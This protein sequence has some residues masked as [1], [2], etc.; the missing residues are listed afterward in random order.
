[1]FLVVNGLF[2]AVIGMGI[3]TNISKNFFAVSRN[4]LAVLIGNML[5]ILFV[6]SLVILAGCL[7]LAVTVDELFSMPAE[8]WLA[9]PVLSFMMMVN[10]INLTLLRNEGRAYV[11][12]GFEVFNTFLSLAVTVV[13]LV[14]FDFGWYSQVIGLL[15]ANAV[16]FLVAIWYIWRRHYLKLTLRRDVIKSILQLS[17]PLIPHV[18]GGVVIAVSDRIFIE[19]MV[20][21]EA[22][23]LYSIGYSFGMVVGLFTDAFVKAW[24]PWFFKVLQNPTDSVRREVVRYTYGYFLG[25][26]ALAGLIAFFAIVL[27]PYVVHDSFLGASDYIFWVSMGCAAQ[28]IYKIFFP[29]LVHINK[30][31]FLAVS[32]VFSAC[33]NLIL[34]YLFI[35]KFGAIGAAYST[36][37]S[38]VLS[39]FLVFVYQ[40]RRFSMPWALWRS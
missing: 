20:G 6:V 10:T 24:T 39:A 13:L 23:A 8:L 4:E 31:S 33:L 15:V 19:R 5:F 7:G 1:M 40:S 21:L 14:V 2:F 3:H 35:L 36:L 29:Y 30:T 16:F 32:T 37:L 22:V 11:Y 18:L 12:A 9:F 27:L 17:L 38:Y 26:F 28:G 34:N 25:V